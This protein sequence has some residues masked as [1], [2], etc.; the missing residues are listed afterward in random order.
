M[1]ALV[2]FPPAAERTTAADARANSYDTRSRS[3]RY[4]CRLPATGGGS[5]TCVTRS[6]GSS[7]VS[8]CGV[9][10][11]RRWKSENGT[12]RDPFRPCT[13]I[14]ASSVSRPRRLM[15]ISCAGVSTFRFIRSI[16]VV[17]PATNR[18]SAPCCAV[19]ALA[20][21]AIAWAGFFGRMNSKLCMTMLPAFV[22]RERC[23]GRPPDLL[24]GGHDVL[25]GAAAADVAAHELLH[26][27]VVRAARLLD[28]D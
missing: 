16:S 15:S 17:P 12:V 27:R 25:I 13:W 19:F 14:V 8:R 3:F 1:R 5:V 4:T 2:T 6:P 26:V 9:L 22:P 28:Q 18:M 21:A 23:S 20:A 24:D 10:P 7:T 11:G